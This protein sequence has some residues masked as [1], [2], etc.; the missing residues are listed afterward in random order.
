V[1]DSVSLPITTP[2]PIDTVVPKPRPRG[3]VPC[4]R[5]SSSTYVGGPAV[6]PGT[7]RHTAEE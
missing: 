2:S 1:P 6:G 7:G 5:T 3:F 4:V